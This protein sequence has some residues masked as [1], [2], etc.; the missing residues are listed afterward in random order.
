MD[1]IEKVMVDLPQDSVTSSSS[2]TNV[3]IRKT[4]AE[5]K[6]EERSKETNEERKKRQKKGKKI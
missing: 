1:S 2:S 6:R 5:R 3:K 4:D